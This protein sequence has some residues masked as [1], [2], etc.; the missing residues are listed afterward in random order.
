MLSHDRVG[1]R[2]LELLAG[3]FPPSSVELV[4]LGNAGLALLDQLRGQELL[5]VVDACVLGGEPGFVHEIEDPDSAPGSF[6][7]VA[8]V[9]QIGPLEALTIARL[10]FPQQLPRKTLLY[11]VE[12]DG[13]EEARQ[14]LICREV[15]E[16]IVARVER[17]LPN[18]AAS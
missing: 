8:S 11:L 18:L 16:R 6:A 9:H 5:V 1:P 10:L 7:G 17:S 12:T 4:N 2:V 15:A 3:R 13:L 14:E